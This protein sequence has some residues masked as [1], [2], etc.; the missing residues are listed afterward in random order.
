MEVIQL[1]ENESIKKKQAMIRNL[2]ELQSSW[3]CAGGI[4]NSRG[5]YPREGYES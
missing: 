3:R 1:V 4:A 5:N 2:T